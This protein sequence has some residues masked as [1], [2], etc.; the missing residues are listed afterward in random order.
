[1]L[2]QLARNEK[3]ISLFYCWRAACERLPALWEESAYIESLT[4][5]LKASRTL[6]DQGAAILSQIHTDGE[7]IET[8]ILH[9]RLLYIMGLSGWWLY[10]KYNH[11]RG[12]DT[13]FKF[14]WSIM[15]SYPELCK[16]LKSYLESESPPDQSTEDIE[17]LQKDFQRDASVA[18][19]DAA[20]YLSGATSDS[21]DCEL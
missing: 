11:T 19:G 8:A 15:S 9:P 13:A 12:K 17:Q 6:Q 10:V 16:A 7:M 5:L 14:L 20:A 4:A 3:T 18:R 2:D 1:M 21:G